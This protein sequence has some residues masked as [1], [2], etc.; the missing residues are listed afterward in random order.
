MFRSLREYIIRKLGGFPDI[1]STIEAIKEKNLDDKYR[2]LT[3]A[4]KKHFNTIGADDILR[5]T[6]TGQWMFEGKPLSEGVRKLI[7]EETKI[8]LGMTLWKVL[9]NDIKYQANRKMFIL[10]TTTDDLT[11]G[12]LWIYTLDALNTR[13]KRIAHDGAALKE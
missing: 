10:S 7:V 12:K 4:V 2:I 6:E 13:L 9:Q 11:A 8:L 3:L 1:D 5:V